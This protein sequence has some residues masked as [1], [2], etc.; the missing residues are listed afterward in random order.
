MLAASPQAEAMAKRTE[1]GLTLQVNKT[2]E[3]ILCPKQ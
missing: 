3:Q 2:A 1:P